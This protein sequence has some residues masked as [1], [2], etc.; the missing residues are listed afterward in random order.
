M[1]TFFVMNLA[2]S[3]QVRGQTT[4]AHACAPIPIA[5]T[6]PTTFALPVEVGSDTYQQ[7]L[8]ALLNTFT[9]ATLP[10]VTR[11]TDSGLVVKC[12]FVSSTWPV[13]QLVVV[14]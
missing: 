7:N 1:P 4:L 10:T 5:N 9:T 11:S 13:G 6:N 14:T 2:Q 12:T 3:N 8:W